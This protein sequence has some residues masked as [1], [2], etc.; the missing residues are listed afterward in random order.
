MPTMHP[1]KLKPNSFPHFVFHLWSASSARKPRSKE[2]S[3]NWNIQASVYAQ[4]AHCSCFEYGLRLEVGAILLDM[5]KLCCKI[6]IGEGVRTQSC[7]VSSGTLQPGAR[8]PVSADPANESRFQFFRP[9][10]PPPEGR[11]EGP[12]YFF[13]GS[14][15]NF[16]WYAV[17]T[18]V[19][20]HLP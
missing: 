11:K 5:R 6:S 3:R 1:V 18:Y 16:S 14:R 13:Q 19:G 17:N 20:V 12:Q 9:R 15:H 4:V 2:P 10:R 8:M 7:W